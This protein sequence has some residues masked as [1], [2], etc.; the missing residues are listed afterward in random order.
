[1][2][3]FASTALLNAFDSD[4]FSFATLLSIG[5]QASLVQITDHDRDV[6]YNASTTY[7]SSNLM[8]GMGEVSETQGVA[9]GGIDIT[10]TGV[11]QTMVSYFLNN[12][13]VG[14][15][16]DIKRAVLNDAGTH[17]GSFTYFNGQVSS[18]SIEDSGDTS[19][20]KVECTSHWADF[21]KING[22]RTNHNSQQ[23][24][25]HYTDGT[26]FSGDD[27]FEFAAKTIKQIRWGKA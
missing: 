21:E 25:K 26:Y 22:R 15:P 11:N 24:T 1:M 5:S 8:L 20:V 16:V 4:S 23:M 6:V 13:Y 7:L 3:R 12:D 9:V 2:A 17:L 27:G 14:L 10:F 18:F 19:E